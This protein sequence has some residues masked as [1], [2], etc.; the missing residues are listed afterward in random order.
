[1]EKDKIYTED[2]IQTVWQQ[3]AKNPHSIVWSD[4]EGKTW[5]DIPSI[6]TGKWAR[7]SIINGNYVKWVYKLKPKETKKLTPKEQEEYA[8]EKYVNFMKNGIE[9]FKEEIRKEF[10]KKDFGREGKIDYEQLYEYAD[11]VINKQSCLIQSLEEKLEKLT[12]TNGE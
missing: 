1:M 12:K 6:D 10:E 3:F 8:E 11:A 4:D 2:E 5:N 9:H 7:F